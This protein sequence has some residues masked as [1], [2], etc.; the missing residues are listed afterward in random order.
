VAGAAWFNPLAPG[1]GQCQNS[2]GK[3]LTFNFPSGTTLPNT[4]VWTVAFNTSDYGSSPIGLQPCSSS[5]GGCP[6]DSLNVGDKS[7]SGAPYV[8][9]DTDPSEAFLNS[10][11][12]GSYCDLGVGGTG[13]LRSDSPCWTGFRPLGEII[14]AP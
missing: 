5:S 8:G 2:I 13:T 6:Y 14:T 3:V 7:Y 10:S 4:V 12:G 11:Y 1:G 9:T